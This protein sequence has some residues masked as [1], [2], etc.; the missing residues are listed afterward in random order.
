MNVEDVVKLLEGTGATVRKTSI[1]IDMDPFVLFKKKI[2]LH[3]KT[4]DNEQ[5][6]RDK[7]GGKKVVIM[8]CADPVDDFSKVNVCYYVSKY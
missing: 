3:K 6:V 1:Q 4:F 2:Y 8:S 7:L 5:E